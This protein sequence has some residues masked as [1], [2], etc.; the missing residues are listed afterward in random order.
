[1]YFKSMDLQHY[2]LNN[3]LKFKFL[4]YF[5]HEEIIMLLLFKLRILFIL[6]WKSG[7]WVWTFWHTIIHSKN[8]I[9][10][11]MKVL[12]VQLCLTIF[13]PRDCSL[14]G[15]SVHGIFQASTLK[16]VAISFSRG[17]FQ[18]Q[19]SNLG[20]PHCRRILYHLSHQG[21]PIYLAITYWH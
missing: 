12:V 4:G 6:Y 7:L 10:L 21:S 16:W 11:K 18:T 17:I 14:P 5:W 13:D 20:L 15:S 9:Y 2:L 3:I 8:P 1:M 19:G